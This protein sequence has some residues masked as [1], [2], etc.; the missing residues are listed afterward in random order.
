MWCVED[1]PRFVKAMAK[2]G[3]EARAETVYARNVPSGHRHTLF[4]GK[5]S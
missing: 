3:F 5:V 1:D 4:I 2:A